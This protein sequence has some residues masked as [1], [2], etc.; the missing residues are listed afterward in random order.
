MKDTW[1]ELND[2]YNS[3]VDLEAIKGYDIHIN[4]SYSNHRLYIGDYKYEYSDNAKALKDY[5]LIK[6]KVLGLNPK[7]IFEPIKDYFTKYQEMFITLGI[8]F[9]I[10]EYLL[11]GKI[12]EKTGSFLDRLLNK[13]ISS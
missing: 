13:K 5:K 10:D 7:N 6:R 2:G 12:R 1:I 8:V 4:K 9:L 3:L 11:K